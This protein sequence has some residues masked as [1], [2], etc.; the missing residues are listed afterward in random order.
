ML[1]GRDFDQVPARDGDGRI[2]PT[3]DISSKNIL[4]SK[5]GNVR[6]YSLSSV[7]HFACDGQFRCG[8]HT[9]FD[10][11]FGGDCTQT[12]EKG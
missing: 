1:G 10:N 4:H 6:T 8:H 12:G 9:D 11:G 3:R 5:A 7:R 2:V